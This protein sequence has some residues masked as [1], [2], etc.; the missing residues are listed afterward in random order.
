MHAR[1][2]HVSVGRD[3]FAYLARGPE[4]GP[5]VL[6]LHGFPDAPPSLLPL[7]DEL[8]RAGYRAVAPWLRGYDPSTLAGPYGPVPLGADALTLASALAPGRRPY[9]VGHDW[10]A[11]A[12]YIAASLAPSRIAAAV[13]M[14]IPHPA[15]LA[16]ALPRHPTQFA[17][18]AYIAAIQFPW[19]PE[20]ALTAAGGALLRQIWRL[21][22]PGIQVPVELE[23]EIARCLKASIPAPLAHYRALKRPHQLAALFRDTDPIRVPTLQ[24]HGAR[25][26]CFSAA[27][28]DHQAH[29]FAADHSFELVH[30]A[31]HF[32]HVE[33]PETVSRAVL[34][35]LE[36]HPQ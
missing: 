31:G 36:A 5:L 19:L 25:D 9:L 1:I 24:L 13:A 21:W 29:H 18:S 15:A 26:G 30:D 28:G 10:G 2:E 23:R 16:R 3:R 7:L 12:V 20:R 35:W 6:C 11:V 22:S 8:A 34:A 4:T 33:S 17:R 32:L 14:A 27:L